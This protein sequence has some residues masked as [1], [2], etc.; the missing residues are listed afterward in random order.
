[1][2]WEHPPVRNRAAWPLKSRRPQTGVIL[3]TSRQPI[4]ADTVGTLQDG[5]ARQSSA[6]VVTTSDH[7]MDEGL[8]QVRLLVE[9]GIDGLVLAG[10][11]PSR[12]RGGPAPPRGAR[13]GRGRPHLR[14]GAGA[15]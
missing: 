10:P 6:L 2:R 9:R 1:M 8:I 15:R 3:P 4:C 5:M 11:K 7:P 12:P 13:H 14:R